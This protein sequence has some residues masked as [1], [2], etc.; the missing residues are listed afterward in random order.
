MSLLTAVEAEAGKLWSEVSGAARADLEK[1]LA[2]AKAEEGKLA[3]LVGEARTDLE[4]IVA[5]VE[6]EI[7]AA[8]SGRLAQLVKDVAALLAAGL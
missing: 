8:V 7:K 3:P 1:A 5:E 6:P 4:A 2:D